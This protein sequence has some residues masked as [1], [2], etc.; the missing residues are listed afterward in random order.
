MPITVK[1]FF[2]RRANEIHINQE[3]SNFR[4]LTDAERWHVQEVLRTI[5]K[6]AE[7]AANVIE[8]G[9]ASAKNE[10]LDDSGELN[11]SYIQIE[12]DDPFWAK[13]AKNRIRLSHAGMAYVHDL[14]EVAGYAKL[15]FPDLTE[16]GFKSR[17]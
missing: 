15:R 9:S 16:F 4:H 1:T 3:Y 14:F 10:L 12:Y 2:E 7:F 13:C 6:L 11:E 5:A 8:S 17:F